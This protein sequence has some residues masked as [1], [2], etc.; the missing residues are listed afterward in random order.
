MKYLP[1]NVY[2]ID[3]MDMNVK[4]VEMKS[5]IDSDDVEDVF[6]E[7]NTLF[8]NKVGIEWEI[9][10]IN[11]YDAPED[12]QLD[13]ISELT[14]DTDKYP[15]TKRMEA[16]TSLIPEGKYSKEF[17]NIYF[18]TFHGNTRQGNANANKTNRTIDVEDD[19]H[20]TMIG[21]YSNKHNNGRKPV[22]RKLLPEDGVPSISFTVAHELG[23]V[24]GLDHLDTNV[25]NVMNGP[26]SSL[27]YTEEQEKTMKESLDRFI[28]IYETRENEI[29]DETGNETD[30]I[31]DIQKEKPNNNSNLKDNTI[32]SG[33]SGVNMNLGDN[34][35]G[36]INIALPDTKKE[37]EDDNSF[38]L[39]VLEAQND[40]VQNINE[41]TKLVEESK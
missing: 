32:D 36:D 39:E 30:E 38:F 34:M 41:I 16:Y 33:D 31:E 29:T 22:K 13:Y 26:T 27:K 14:R 19:I 5:W 7:I 8:F 11:I 18:T 1:I 23:H 21:T 9:N 35:A 6:E 37:D 28:Q 25:D 2:I 17:N 3:N 40:R 20:F 24:L 15:N 10:E 4:G 12:S